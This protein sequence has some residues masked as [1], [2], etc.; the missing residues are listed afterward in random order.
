M[1]PS[2]A[3]VPGPR[4]VPGGA[5]LPPVIMT[6]DEDQIAEYESRARPIAQSNIVRR[7]SFSASAPARS[8]RHSTM[9]PMRSGATRRPQIRSIVTFANGRASRK[10][11]NPSKRARISSVDTASSQSLST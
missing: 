9:S 10:R 3:H 4:Y 7:H 1:K 2:I 5:R 6:I 8:S 11:R